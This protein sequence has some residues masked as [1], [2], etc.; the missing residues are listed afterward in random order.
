[1]ITYSQ[2]DVCIDVADGRTDNWLR[3]G[4]VKMIS[5]TIDDLSIFLSRRQNPVVEVRGL[6]IGD[7][8]ASWLWAKLST[9]EHLRIRVE[10][11]EVTVFNG[12]VISFASAD[13]LH[14]G[15]TVDFDMVVQSVEGEP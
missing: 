6:N 15:W 14:T 1:M 9:M 7:Q 3:I 12:I 8:N 10:C 2:K 4:H 13:S 5:I 11:P